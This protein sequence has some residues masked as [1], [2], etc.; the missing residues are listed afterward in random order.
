MLLRIMLLAVWGDSNW[1]HLMQ[2]TVILPVSI[3][4]NSKELR[5]Q[6]IALLAYISSQVKPGEDCVDIKTK[7]Y[8]QALGVSVSTLRRWIKKLE[9]LGILVFEKIKKDVRHISRSFKIYYDKIMG[10]EDE[11]KNKAQ[12][13]GN[14]NCSNNAKP[15]A[16]ATWIPDQVRDDKVQVQ[17]DKVLLQDDGKRKIGKY[18]VKDEVLDTLTVIES[19]ALRGELRLRGIEIDEGD[20][21]ALKA[22]PETDMEFTN[23]VM[24]IMQHRHQHDAMKTARAEKRKNMPK[25][26]PVGS[27][28]KEKY[29]S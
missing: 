18:C 21:A 24:G 16:S 12:S 6:G 23:S 19:F 13:D 7:D 10:K 2:A 3:F 25:F 27:Y 28:Y 14:D 15:K 29:G 8:A 1:R 4:D 5:A 17:N 11:N 20:I 9:E 26:V 22:I